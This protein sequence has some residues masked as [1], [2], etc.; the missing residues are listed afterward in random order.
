MA[1]IGL[2]ALFIIL[3]GIAI[4]RLRWPIRTWVTG[5][6]IGLIFIGLAIGGALTGDVYPNVRD[7]YNANVHTTLR[8]TKSFTA[9][10]TTNANSVNI[11]LVPSS[12][13]YVSLNYYGRPDLASI[14]TYVNNGTLV[15]DSSQFNWHRN[16]QV[17]CIPN[18]YKMTITVYT[19]DAMQLMN[20]TYGTPM[21]PPPP[22]P[23]Q[24]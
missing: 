6:L 9:I 18:T 22:K 1:V 20:Q 8:T 19:P 12:K 14:K 4:F 21:I 16:C 17:I 23:Y 10:N 24:P 5:M 7:R 3:F 2:T 11:N 15:I 13:Y